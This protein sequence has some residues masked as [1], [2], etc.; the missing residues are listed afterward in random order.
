VARS[1]FEQAPSIEN[2]Q[3]N[4]EIFMQLSQLIGNARFNFIAIGI[5]VSAFSPAN[6][7]NKSTGPSRVLSDPTYLPRAR[8]F[9]GAT[10]YSSGKDTADAQDYSGVKQYSSE[11]QFQS[12]YQS[13]AYGFTDRF[14]VGASSAY[15][16]GD[17][18]Y[19]YTSGA[20]KSA[21]GSGGGVSLGATY[22]VLDQNDSPVSLDL[23]AVVRTGGSPL[24]IS[25]GVGYKTERFTIKGLLGANQ[26][27][28]GSYTAQPKEVPAWV[29]ASQR[30]FV[31]IQTQ[32]RMTDSFSVNLGISYSIPTNSVAALENGIP[33]TVKF[34]DAVSASV[35]LNYHFIANKLVGQLGYDYTMISAA[36]DQYA[37][38]A[39]NMTINSHT[40][41]S[42]FVSLRYAF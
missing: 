8:Q 18:D 6:A 4:K 1:N 27:N 5:L 28:G 2:I 13:L 7:Q 39:S 40:A 10:E 38:P 15:S 19:R 41:S 20:L 31:A 36:R 22:R 16:T 30:Y 17:T 35:A 29:D 33:Y 24:G 21:H 37:D 14:S 12:G 32:T 9:V 23:S 25:A 34:P 11:S 3:F 26:F 42:L